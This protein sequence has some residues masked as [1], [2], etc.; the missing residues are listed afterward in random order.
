MSLAIRQPFTPWS[1]LLGAAAQRPAQ[2]PPRAPREIAD[3]PA[4]AP[5]RGASL[6]HRWA[7]A[8]LAAR[9]LAYPLFLNPSRR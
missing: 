6:F 9:D 3:E 8:D 7:A 4:R 5:G 2:S 1:A